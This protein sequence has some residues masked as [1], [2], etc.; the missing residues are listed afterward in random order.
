MISGLL[1]FLIG[2]GAWYLLQHSGEA[3][4]FTLT[5]LEGNVFRLS[6]FRGRVVLLEFMAT[7]CG[8][9]RASMP[10][11]KEIWTRYSRQIVLISISVDPA[12]DTED[13]LIEWTRHYGAGW[14]HARDTSD[15]RVTQLYGIK[16][17]PT[18]IL[19]DKRGIIRYRYE[20]LT[21]KETLSER[22]AELLRE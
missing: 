21:S 10:S 19:I 16:V 7:W 4:D 6:D 14:I 15:P 20:G 5:D 9:C 12:S 8:A 3:P 13:V 1:L 22:I 11:L 17:I 2:V 18:Y